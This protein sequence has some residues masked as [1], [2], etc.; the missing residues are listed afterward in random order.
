MNLLYCSFFSHTQ[1]V[2]VKSEQ[3]QLYFA[4][5]SINKTQSH[6]IVSE[7]S[8]WGVEEFCPKATIAGKLS[9]LPPNSNILFIIIHLTW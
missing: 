9:Q 6:I 7:D 2:L 8:W 1:K 3:Y 5:I 4:H